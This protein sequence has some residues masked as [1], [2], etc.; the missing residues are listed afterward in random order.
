M[1]M[2]DDAYP[3]TALQ[4]GMLF[5]SEYEAGLATYHDVFTVTLRG[6]YDRAA[7]AGAFAEV[8]TRHAVLR[9][10]F[11]LTDFSEPLQLVHAA[12]TVPLAETDLSGLEPDVAAAQLQVWRDEEKVTGFDWSCPPLLRAFVHQLPGDHQPAYS[13]TLSFHHAILDGWSVASLLTEL[14]GRYTACLRGEPLP[15]SPLPVTFRD[16]VAVEREQV[17]ADKPAA[18]WRDALSDAPANRLPRAPGFPL[19]ETEAIETVECAIDGEVATGLD[20]LAHELKVPLRTVLLAAHLRALGLLTGEPDVTTGVVTH[21]RPEREAAEQVLGLFLNSVPVRVRVDRSSWTALVQA[22]FDAEVALLPYRRYPLFEI[23]RA[24]G[25]SP[26]FEVL[27]DYRDFHVYGDLPADGPLEVVGRDFFEQTNLPFA[28]AFS[29]SRGQALALVLTYDRNQFPRAQVE[30]AREHYLRML[31]AIASDPAG[32]PRDTSRHLATDSRVIASWNA[33]GKVYPVGPLPELA[34][35]QAG[36]T[37][38]APAL[39]AAGEW[40]SYAEFAASVNRLARHLRTSG[41][42]TGDVVGVRLERGSDLV[43]TA[44]AVVAAGAAY[45]PLE[46]DYPDERLAFMTADA[47]ARLVITADSLAAGAS[48]IAAHPDTRPAVRVPPDAPAY[49]IYTS[50]STGRPKGVAISHRAI[51]NRLH[52]MQDVFPLTPADRV[53]HKTPFSFDV[54]VWELFWPLMAGAGLAIAPPGAHGDST[55]LAQLMADHEVSTVHFVPSMLDAFLEEPELELPALRRVICSGEALSTDLAA[56]CAQ[57]LPH[58]ELHNLYGPTEAAVDVTWHPHRP[59]ETL[60]PIGAP[61]ANTRTEVV[62]SDVR[63]VPIGTPG[64]LRLAGVQL[65]NGYL[66]RPALTAERFTPDPFGPPGTRSY[67]TGDLARWLPNGEIDYLGRLDHQVKI[68]G[69]RIE[70]GE[71]EAALAAVPGVRSAVVTANDAGA[72]P[73]LTAYLVPHNG[74]VPGDAELRAHLSRQL[75]AY[76]IPAA[77]VQLGELPLTSNGKLDRT[78]LPAPQSARAGVYRPPR[79]SVEARLATIWE[80]LLGHAAI[81]VTEDFFALGGH[82]LLALRLALRIRQEFGRDLPVATVLTSPT[83]GQLALEIR[84]PEDMG[85]TSPI[86]PLRTTGDRPALFLSHALGGQVFRYRPLAARLGDDQPVYTIPA[87]GLAP[88]EEPHHTLAEMADDYA[89]YIRSV[90][91]H[92]PYVLGGFCI[93][94]NIAMEVARRLRADGEEV[95]V[96]FAVWSSA[97]EPVVRSS[98]EDETML[99]IHAL[100]GG[101]NVLETVDLDELRALDTDERLVAVVRA[102]ARE[103]RLRPDTADLEQARRYLRVFKANAQALGFYRHQPYDGDLVLLQPVEDPEITPGD[104]YGWRRVVS[105]RFAIAPIPGTRFTSIYEPLVSDMAA[106]MRRW[107]DRGFTDDR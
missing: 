102:A 77:Y 26:L 90:R 54:S 28:A 19:G 47:A 84:R 87:R 16:F 36:R 44:H 68:R 63:R 106:Q 38:E 32:D 2:L 8:V 92:G 51:V 17:A 75:P 55:A 49:V 42:R 46:P 105:G 43:I 33:T 95:P 93:G 6:P 74:N 12:A 27:F 62:D 11:N 52:W 35:A 76:M 66:N 15:V 9:T 83:I 107:M 97:D 7:L 14:L 69:F 22:V 73:A 40:L 58:A 5:H 37:P 53:L 70:L 80:Q 24:A 48:A 3:L 101:V 89:G 20:R 65:A 39:W 45:L 100:A 30:Q 103:E 4:A 31:A 29:R 13:L 98:V 67:R 60:V 10:S 41:V 71:I 50:G 64:E 21:G 88:G 94:G 85:R 23:Q 18:F 78:A 99:M 1:T 59:G 104:D 56:R 25:R 79:D 57:R 61:I 81:G 96:V 72:G 34:A 82:S 86:V 91:P